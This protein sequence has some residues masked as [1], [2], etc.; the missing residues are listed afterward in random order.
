MQNIYR[1]FGHVGLITYNILANILLKRLF[2]S[3]VYFSLEKN[4]TKLEYMLTLNLA[5]KQ[6][7]STQVC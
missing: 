6:K 1:K 4:S 7:F 3:P 2:Q 5:E